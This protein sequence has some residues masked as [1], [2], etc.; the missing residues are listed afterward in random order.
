MIYWIF[1]MDHTLYNCN[2][3]P[4]NYNLLK[5]DN[6]LI[7]LINKLNGRKILFTNAAHIH[8]NMVLKKLGLSSSF[9]LI[10]D[11]DTLGVLK[12][13]VAAFIKLIHWCSITEK[14]TCY[15][16]EDTIQNLIM[17]SLLGW[18][19]VLISPTDDN[20]LNKPIDVTLFDKKTNS[21]VKKRILVNYTF[22]NIKMALN[23]FHSRLL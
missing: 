21:P 16:F 14:D 5:K 22:K 8:T 15:F 23:H 1:D 20:S 18:Q 13:N 4:F 11:R 6:E 3:Q 19:S 2:N 9:D 7:N 17:G 10:V 12:P